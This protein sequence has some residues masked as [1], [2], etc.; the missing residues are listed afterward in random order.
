[1]KRPIVIVLLTIALTLVCLGIGAVIYFANGFQTNNPF[2]K[3]NIS[4]VVEENK[5][6]KVDTEKPLILNVTSDSGD[7]TVTGAEVDI[8]QIKAVKTAYD[9]SQARADEDVKGVKYTIEQIGNTVTIKYELP[10]SANFGNNVNTVDFIVIVPVETTVDANTHFGEVSVANTKGNV[11]VKNDFGDVTAENIEGALTVKTNSGEVT[12][13][14]IMAGSE[15]IDLS[16]DFGSVTLKKASAKD[17][18]LDSNSGTITLSEIRATGD[19]TT[20]TDFGNTKF[21][22]GSADS[23][24]TETNSGKVSLVKIT[25]KKQIFIKDDFGDIDL[26]Q[27]FAASYDLRK[28]N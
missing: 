19:I 7:V 17:I 8:V 4:S 21:E 15:N 9:S 22:N 24:H 28:A 6:L 3:R 20:N 10:K 23:L 12:A 27:S 25:V 1:M 13:T 11:N 5:T 14:S 18:M 26:E 2:D 16:S